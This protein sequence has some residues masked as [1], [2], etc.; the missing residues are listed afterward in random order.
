[1]PM[2]NFIVIIPEFILA[3][4]SLLLLIVG[5]F[6]RKENADLILHLAGICLLV[7]IGVILSQIVSLDNQS[8]VVFEG[9]FI[10]DIFSKTMKIVMLTLAGCVLLLT[11]TSMYQESIAK[12]EYPIL[13]LLAVLGMMFMVS[14]KG[15]LTLFM[16]LEL[17]SLSLYILSSMKRN[18][19]RSSEAGMKYFLLGA[20]STGILLYGISL[21]YGATGGFSFE[22]V[23]QVVEITSAN[24][25]LPMGLLIG[26]TF[27]LAGMVFKVSVVPFHMWTPDVYEGTPTSITTFISTVPKI[28]AYGMLIRLLMDPFGPAVAQWS[29]LLMVLSMASMIL[30]SFAILNQR[31]LKRFIAYSAI[32]NAGYSLMGLMTGTAA[33]VQATLLYVILYAVS[34]FGFF[35]CLI[36]LSRRGEKVETISDL[37]GISKIYPGLTFAMVFLLFSMAGVPPLAGFFG[38]LYVFNS[39]LQANFIALAIVGVLTS[40][41]AAAYYLWVIKVMTMDELIIQNWTSPSQLN[42]DKMSLFLMAMVLISLV[43]FFIKPSFFMELLSKA[44]TS[45]FVG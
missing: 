4:G 12:F 35:C 26:F 6:Q 13:I 41:V 42:E 39:A 18:D 10:H 21:I 28:A 29:W 27:V 38:K 44:A 17:Q 25:G 11:R 43:V 1:M 45:L 15:F 23:R 14:A 20:L 16:G 19:A 24:G 40:V 8:V 33:G 32:A 9:Q 31:N 3:L 36:T 37:S 30:A 7:S 5:A 2:V 22:L 34:V